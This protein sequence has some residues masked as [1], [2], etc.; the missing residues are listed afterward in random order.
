MITSIAFALLLLSSGVSSSEKESLSDYHII[1]LKLELGTFR[2]ISD[3][4]VK[5]IEK[6]VD[7]IEASEYLMPRKSL[8]SLNYY[9]LSKKI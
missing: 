9:K 6:R 1:H 5:K 3:K 7:L 4:V 8:V 2:T